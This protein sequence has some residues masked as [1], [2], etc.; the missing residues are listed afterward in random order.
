MSGRRRGMRQAL[1]SCSCV[2]PRAS[3]LSIMRVV[4]LRGS[5]LVEVEDEKLERTLCLLPAKFSKSLWIKRGNYVLVEEADRQKLLDANAKVT[6]IISQVLYRDHVK[7]LQK[8]GCWPKGFQLTEP[9]GCSQPAS[10]NKDLQVEPASG[11]S[12]DEEDDLPALEQNTNRSRGGTLYLSSS[13]SDE[14]L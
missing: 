14:D 2:D 7:E 10:T 8:T 11:N 4:A 3:G 9:K 12:S 5:N 13:E 6:G 1:D